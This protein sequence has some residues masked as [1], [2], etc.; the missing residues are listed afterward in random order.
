MGLSPPSDFSDLV[1]TY[2]MKKDFNYLGKKSSKPSRTLDTFDC[3]KDITTIKF[4]SNELTTFCPVTGQPD[5]NTIIIEYEPNKK[6]I[7]SKS[8]KLYLWSYRDE[9]M[10]AEKLAHQIA[11]DVFKATKPKWCRATLIQNIRGGLQLTVV[12]ERK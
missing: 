9:A 11:D 8:L 2:F 5:F 1:K 3:P 4:E 6:C 7:E 10:F 12:A